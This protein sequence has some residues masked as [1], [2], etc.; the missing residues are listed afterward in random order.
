MNSYQQFHDGAF[1][2]FLIDGRTVD[3]FVSTD[4]KEQFVLTADGVIALTANGMQTG[5]VILD[6]ESWTA[7][8]LTLR[9]ICDVYGYRAGSDDDRHANSALA[10][11]REAGLVML[12]VNPSYGGSC[13]LLAKSVRLATRREWLVA[14]GERM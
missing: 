1:D 10:S 12:A 5:N 8:E 13:L 11:S 3:L 2:G 7:E 14:K 9:D 6:V 4:Q